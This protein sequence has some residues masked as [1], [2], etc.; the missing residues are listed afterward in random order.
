MSDAISGKDITNTITSKETYDS[1]RTQFATLL[2][3]GVAERTKALGPNVSICGPVAF[4]PQPK[5]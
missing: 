2:R 1:V 4:E 5:N 3:E